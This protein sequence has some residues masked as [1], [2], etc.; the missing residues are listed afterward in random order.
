LENSTRIKG[1]ISSK[2]KDLMII[3]QRTFYHLRR[4]ASKATQN[5]INYLT[6][7]ADKAIAIQEY[8]QKGGEQRE[9]GNG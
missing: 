3:L 8:K 7:E 4:K 9:E 6:K 5:K 2:E 1:P